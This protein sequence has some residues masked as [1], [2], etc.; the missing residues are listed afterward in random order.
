M[1]KLRIK[2]KIA[3]NMAN[4]ILL[5]KPFN[6]LSQF[7]D[8]QGRDTLKKYLPNNPGFHPAGRLDFD[9]EGLMLLT[10][11]GSLQ[12][13]ISDPK[14]KAPKTY[15]VQVEGEISINNINKL[16]QGIDLKD[17]LTKKATAKIINEPLLWPRT[18]PI[19]ER[20]NIPTS[21]ISLTIIEGK[22]RQVRRMTAAVGHPTLRLIRASIGDWHL[23]N[24]QPGEYRT[25]TVNIPKKIKT[26]KI[27]R[28]S[29]NAASRRKSRR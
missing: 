7:T 8:D 19:R 14:H 6:V 28:Q 15:W 3:P 5:N 1:I 11:D 2:G 21:W 29:S 25:E 24:L 27:R 26:P 4:I 16:S 10:D 20:K 13:Q 12:H 17:G 18:P 23:D 22:N 9:S